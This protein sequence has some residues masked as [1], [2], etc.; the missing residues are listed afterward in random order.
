M[1]T[2]QIVEVAAGHYL[3][4]AMTRGWA[5]SDYYGP[6][7]D[8]TSLHEESFEVLALAVAEGASLDE[9]EALAKLINADRVAELRAPVPELSD[10]Q[11]KIF[12]VEAVEPSELDERNTSLSS[13]E[14][15]H[16]LAIDWAAVRSNVE[17]AV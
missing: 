9:I 7:A 12:G 15:A 11:R 10:T 3:L 5:E 1:L 4:C 16:R 17:G 6:K 14:L 13:L 8:L 2:K